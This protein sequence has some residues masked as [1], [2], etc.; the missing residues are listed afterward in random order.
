MKKNRIS[1]WQK[2]KKERDDAI[3]LNKQFYQ[4]I[5]MAKTEAGFE[6]GYCP[7]PLMGREERRVPLN[8]AEYFRNIIKNIPITSKDFEGT[9]YR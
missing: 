7:I 1:P 8:D 6:T 4:A 9:I 2:L 3:K 5:W